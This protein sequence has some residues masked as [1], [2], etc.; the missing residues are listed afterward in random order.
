MKFVKPRK[1]LA[2]AEKMSANPE[3]FGGDVF[4][5]HLVSQMQSG[6]CGQDIS[7]ISVNQCAQSRTYVT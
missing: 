3:F 1:V 2:N 4:L 5:R 7:V 6:E